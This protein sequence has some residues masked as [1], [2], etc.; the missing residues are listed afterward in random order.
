MNKRILLLNDDLF[1]A[2][3][4]ASAMKAQGYE[5]TTC[6]TSEDAVRF[7]NEQTPSA[8]CVNLTARHFDPL[9]LAQQLK[10]DETLQKIPLL[11]F[12]GHVEDEKAKQAKEAGYDLVAPNSAMAMSLA[13]VLERLMK[14]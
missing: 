7:A 8:I 4:V 14:T 9:T 6:E 2:T 13:H 11:G 5:V 10:G 12:C 3:N 1:S